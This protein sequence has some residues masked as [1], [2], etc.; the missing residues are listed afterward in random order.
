MKI[1]GS[2]STMPGC[3]HVCHYKG[4]SWKETFRL[5]DANK[6]PIDLSGA[7]VEIHIRAKQ[8]DATPAETLTEGDGITIGGIDGNEIAINK[9]VEL[10][11]GS[12]YW[13]LQVIFDDLTVRT[14][15]AG[16]FIVYQDTTFA[17][18]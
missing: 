1:G 13:D 17:T 14:L 10:D 6:A 9:I 15:L 2:N 12:Y 16:D 7:A 11:A 5:R 18:S 8:T 4:D 3:Y